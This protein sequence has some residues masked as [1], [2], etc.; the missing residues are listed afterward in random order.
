MKKLL[1]CCLF[2]L[3]VFVFSCRQ[4][5]G[6][7]NK[8]NLKPLPE[9]DSNVNI[10]KVLVY[11][12]EATL[13]AETYE[14]TVSKETVS[15]EILGNISV[16]LESLKSNYTVKEKNSLPLGNNTGDSK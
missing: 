14:Y 11:E 7:A 13:N 5:S 16:E 3:V 2:L 10:K 8:N 4:D 1:K 12:N 6:N 15:S 9:K